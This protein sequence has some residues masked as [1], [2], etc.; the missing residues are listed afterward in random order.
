M[1]LMQSPPGAETLIDG[2]RYLYFGGTGYLGLQGHPEVIRV[3]CEALQQYG[4][5]AAT[6]RSGYGNTPPTVELERQAA[7][8]FDLED[9]FHVTSGYVANHVLVLACEG[10]FETVFVD[11]LSHYSIREATR[12]SGRRIYTFRHRD[13]EDL[14]RNLRQHLPA[15]GRPLVMTDGV[16]AALGRV[17][18]V[19]EYRDVLAE[20]PGAILAVDDAHGLGVLGK[21]GRGTYEH[22]GLLKSVN[23]SLPKPSGMYGGQYLLLCGT[24]SKAAGGFGGIIPGSRTLVERLK[25][26]SPYY[27]GASAAPI[28]VAAA[29]ARGLLLMRTQPALRERLWENVRVVKAG[30]RQLGLNVDATPVPIIPLT[31]GTADNMQ[32]IHAE[33]LDRGILIPYMPTYSGLGPAGALRLAVFTTHTDAML[34]RLLDELGRVI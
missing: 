6:A 15:N 2:R 3:A 33:L 34:A 5:G 18:P 13:P 29:T 16:F 17:A 11:E 10:C 7:V 21:N 12:L 19:W 32:R 22:V 26:T 14:R 25:S 8:F 24:L 28:P 1:S 31:I 9:A 23:G 20:Y 30:L 27:S 4:L